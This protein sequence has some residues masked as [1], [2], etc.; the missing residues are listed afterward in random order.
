MAECMD[1][2]H[3]VGKDRDRFRA[4]EEPWVECELTPGF[5]SILGL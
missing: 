3:R 2:E 5:W 1:A 4:P